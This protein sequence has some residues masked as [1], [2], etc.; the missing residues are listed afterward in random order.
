MSWDGLWLSLGLGSTDDLRGE[1][2]THVKMKVNG[3][4]EFLVVKGTARISLFFSLTEDVPPPSKMVREM[5]RVFRGYLT[6]S[7][8]R[9]LSQPV[10]K[11]S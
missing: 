11:H 5:E 10:S 7:G 6:V 8:P 3:H 9:L 4:T 1:E 2:G